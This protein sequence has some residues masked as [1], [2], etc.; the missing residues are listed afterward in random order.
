M[1]FIDWFKSS[2]DLVRHKVDQ[3]IRI[4]SVQGE[5]KQLTRNNSNLHMKIAS[6]VLKLHKEGTLNIDKLE[7]FSDVIGENNSQITEK[8][9]Q[10]TFIRAE[11]A[12]AMTICSDCWQEIPLIAD[13][14]PNCGKK[15]IK[16]L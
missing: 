16:V 2:I 12:F 11:S 4:N 1:S 13:F 15:V 10:I 8:Q 7:E 3:Q 14:C 6:T 9:K 5:I